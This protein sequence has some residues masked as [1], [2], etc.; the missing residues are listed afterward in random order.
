MIKIYLQKRK[1]FTIY[2][3]L[4][5]KNVNN[6]LHIL[7]SMFFYRQLIITRKTKGCNKEKK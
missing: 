3:N 1:L 6:F 2:K 5:T 7:V 4:S